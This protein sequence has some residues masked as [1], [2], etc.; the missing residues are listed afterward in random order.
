MDHHT[1]RYHWGTVCKPFQDK[2]RSLRESFYLTFP[3]I[4]SVLPFSYLPPLSLSPVLTKTYPTSNTRIPF[5]DFG[6]IYSLCKYVPGFLIDHK[7]K[8]KCYGF[9]IIFELAPCS[10]PAS[11]ASTQSVNPMLEPRLFVIYWAHL[12]RWPLLP[13]DTSSTISVCENLT[14]NSYWAQITVMKAY[15]QFRLDI[16]F[17]IFKFFIVLG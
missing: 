15:L 3:S 12:W 4:S 17:L 7:M 11:R 2:H 8:T 16:T 13:R 9:E 1:S 10:V 5:E 14:C 6:Q